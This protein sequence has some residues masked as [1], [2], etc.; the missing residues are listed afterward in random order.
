MLSREGHAARNVITGDKDTILFR[1][2][3][4]TGSQ[5]QVTLYYHNDNFISKG[6]IVSYNGANY[7]TINKAHWESDAHF[8]SNAIKCN[9]VWYLPET[10]IPVLVEELQQA[11]PTVG[12]V[13]TTTDGY[14]QVRTTDIEYFHTDFPTNI[15]VNIW[16][17]AY[18]LVNKYFLDG[19]CYLYF[20][21]ETAS[22]TL[23]PELTCNI[24]DYYSAGDTITLHPYV[25]MTYSDTIIYVPDATFTFESNDEETAVCEDHIIYLLQDGSPIITIT[26]T[27]TYETGSVGYTDISLYKEVTLNVDSSSNGLK[28]SLNTTTGDTTIKIG[29]SYKTIIASFTD[30]NGEDVTEATIADM[31]TEDFVWAFTIDG[32]DAS[33][34]I[35][36]TTVDG[37]VN[38]YRVKYGSDKTYITKTLLVTCICGD[39]TATLEFTIAAV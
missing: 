34:Q 15:Q 7:L 18:Y 10:T 29:G 36:T 9:Q 37:S 11:Q 22:M 16:G 14:V 24:N 27:G 32:E 26:A 25:T 12:S 23:S 8:K 1:R 39:M 13:I 4:A 2:S 30:A 31:T 35:T 38:Y 21:R 19:V 5:E 6:D 3:N 17:G 20:V 33:D 28:M